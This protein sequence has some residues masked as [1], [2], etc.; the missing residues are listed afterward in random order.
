MGSIIVS[1]VGNFGFVDASTAFFGTVGQWIIMTVN[2]IHEEPV[3]A[4]GKIE[5][6]KMININCAIDH[7]YLHTGARG[8]KL[9]EIFQDVFEHPEKYAQNK[10]KEKSNDKE[11]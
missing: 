8:K 1:P 7:R 2:A 11:K 3:V 10:S 9:V 6:A 4:N 5:I